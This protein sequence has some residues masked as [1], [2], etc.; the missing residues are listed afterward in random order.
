MKSPDPCVE[1]ICLIDIKIQKVNLNAHRFAPQH[2]LA[3]QPTLWG[4]LDLPI[5]PFI[6]GR[7][8]RVRTPSP[9]PQRCA[10]SAASG[11]TPGWGAGG[12]GGAPGAP[13][14]LR[15]QAAD[16]HG[17]ARCARQNPGCSCD[18]R[19]SH[20]SRSTLRETKPGDPTTGASIP[21]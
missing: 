21:V 8:D 18:S 12:V 5:Y 16:R 17:D 4:T 11:D 7:G 10:L 2:R 19:R 3:R 9:A 13:V 1:F 20:S 15:R 14:A 6:W